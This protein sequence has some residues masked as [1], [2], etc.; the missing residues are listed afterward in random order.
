[1]L[2]FK[3]L[4]WI[5]PALLVLL[6]AIMI[7][8]PD[9]LIVE[10]KSVEID[11]SE[12]VLTGLSG[13]IEIV[14]NGLVRVSGN[15]HFIGLYDLGTGKLH[16][17]FDFGAVDEKGLLQKHYPA[18]N[19]EV[20]YMRSDLESKKVIGQSFPSYR[21]YYAG[22]LEDKDQFLFTYAVYS[23]FSVDDYKIANYDYFF[24]QADLDLNPLEITK[25]NFNAEMVHN[26]RLRHMDMGFKIVEDKCYT[27]LSTIEA[28]DLSESWKKKEVMPLNSIAEKSIGS[29]VQKNSML[30]LY[31]KIEGEYVFSRKL[32]IPYPEEFESLNQELNTTVRYPYFFQEHDSQVYFSNNKRIYN[33]SDETEAYQN[34]LED[35]QN[36][37]LQNFQFSKDG[38]KIYYHFIEGVHSDDGT[39][40]LG[41]YDVVAKRRIYKKELG[42]T[43]DIHGVDFSNDQVVVL[44]R[45]DE[46]YYLKEY[47]IVEHIKT[48]SG[49]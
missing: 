19:D 1:V 34:I 22:Y 29:K 21:S 2:R 39:T 25:N 5:V 23:P 45:N 37:V 20:T 49:I 10:T 43:S 13:E 30:A 31:E 41:V 36:E 4:Y 35:Y 11:E 3:H 9:D 48:P 42:R 28:S 26:H 16:R 44:V 7:P 40:Y 15:Q 6:T 24:V 18:I 12:V 33:V 27:I 46:H 8:Q 32:N 47:A 14:P 17:Q 38:K